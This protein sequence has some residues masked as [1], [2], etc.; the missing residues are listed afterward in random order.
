MAYV[1]SIFYE[2]YIY[3]Y[4]YIAHTKSIYNLHKPYKWSTCR[5]YIDGIKTTCIHQ[6]QEL[7]RLSIHVMEI[8]CRLHFRLQI[9]AYK[10]R[11]YTLY[12]ECK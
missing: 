2:I 8:T 11:E 7:Y 10:Q 1:H 3:I 12:I 5:W 6:Q 4:I 9:I